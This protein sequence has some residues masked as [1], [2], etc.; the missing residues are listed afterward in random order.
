M[1]AGMAISP[2]LKINGEVAMAMAWAAF[3]IP[4]SMTIVR[5]TAGVEPPSRESRELH[6]MASR[7]RAP[8]AS[9]RTDRLSTISRGY[10][11]KNTSARNIKAGNAALPRTLLTLAAAS[12][13][14]RR[15]RA[16]ARIGTKSST[17]FWTTSLPT[18]RLTSTPDCSDTKRDTTSMMTGRV[19]RV[20]TL[21]I[22][23]RVTDRATSPRASIENTLEELPP[24]QQ[25]T[26]TSPMK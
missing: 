9:P 21:L 3:C 14:K 20:I 1:M 26:R 13:R 22:A 11:R 7:M 16:P 5:R 10:C 4:T 23:V 17:R 25:A 18:G 15:K 6:S 2:L 12:G 8:A 19:N 24:G